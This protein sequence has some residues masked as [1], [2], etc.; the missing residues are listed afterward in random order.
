MSRI[1]TLG[2]GAGDGRVEEGMS[3]PP[4]LDAARAKAQDPKLRFRPS[5]GVQI[6]RAIDRLKH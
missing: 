1:R 3:S 5:L 6:A 4:V 2:G